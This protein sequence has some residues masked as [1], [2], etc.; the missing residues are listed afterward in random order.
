MT[1]PIAEKMTLMINSR[2]ILRKERL[3]EYQS[4]IIEEIKYFIRGQCFW[5]TA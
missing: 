1:N 2:N 4:L 3:M 5:S